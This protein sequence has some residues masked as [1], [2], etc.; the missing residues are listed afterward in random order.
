MTMVNMSLIFSFLPIHYQH[1]RYCLMM[2]RFFEYIYFCHKTLKHFVFL[3]TKQVSCSLSSIYILKAV[4]WVFCQNRLIGFL[5]CLNLS[6]SFLNPFLILLNTQRESV[7]YS[8]EYYFVIWY[9]KYVIWAWNNNSW[10]TR[11]GMASPP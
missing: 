8:W 3:S 7:I 4:L 9:D 10:C 5:T 6:V 1:Y 2:Y 11:G